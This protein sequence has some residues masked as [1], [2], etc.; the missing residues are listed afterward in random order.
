MKPVFKLS[1]FAPIC[2]T[3][4]LALSA[5]SKPDTP[6]TLIV[7]DW[8]QA[9]VLVIEQAGV[10]VSMKDGAVSYAKDG[11]SKGTMV[12]SIGGLP[13]ELANYNINTTGTWRIEE[14]MLV[15]AIV[16]A[17]VT[18]ASGSPQAA[19]IASQVQVGMLAQAE[20]SSE[21]RDL[22]KAVLVVH[23]PETDTTMTFKR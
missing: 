23:Q 20:A 8:K 19:A 5:C 17:Q 4:A 21:I 22:T 18:S 9:E 16:D 2:V 13:D 3:A 6:E 12:M 14:N 7:G 15:E 11:S 1:I 10:A